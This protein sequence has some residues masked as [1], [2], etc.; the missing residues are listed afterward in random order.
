MRFL[1]A[2]YLLL[3]TS[4]PIPNG[5]VVV[6]DQNTIV[7]IGTIDDFRSSDLEVFSGVLLPGF[8][9]THCHLELSH[10]KSKCDTGTQLIPFISSVLKFRE[11][12]QEVIQACI[13]QED[14]NM[15]NAGIQAVGDI[16]NKIDTADCKEKSRIAYYTFVEMFDLMQETMTLGTIENYRNVFKLQSSKSG[17]KKSFVPHAPY[18]VSEALFK[19]IND[20]NPINSTVSIHNQETLDENNLFLDGSGEFNNFYKSINLELKDFE[21]IGKTSIAYALKNLKPKARN[22]F[23]H[24]T[25]T[26]TEDIALAQSWS[27]N[28]YWA[29][30]P[31]ANLYIENRLPNYRNFIETN[32]TMTIGTDSIMSNWQLCIWEEI[33]TIKKYQSYVPLSEL[34][35]WSTINGAEALGYKKMLGSLEVGKKPGVINIDIDWNNGNA[36]I[37]NTS[38]NRVI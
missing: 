8:I 5:V 22:L 26:T 38:P 27:D 18:S 12:E 33:K 4:A 11:F 35:K 15:W 7:E 19:F 32:A 36:D 20:A 6:D 1:T 10:M 24:N 16:S 29:T 31:N 14:Q 23:V 17:N 13:F 37:I 3:I 30:C 28:V 21:P 2:D 9:N 25:L 34:L